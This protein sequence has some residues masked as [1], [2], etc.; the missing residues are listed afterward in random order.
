MPPDN[1]M[2]TGWCVTHVVGSVS[3][4]DL[5][6]DDCEN[7]IKT[8]TV[9]DFIV[10]SQITLKNIHRVQDPRTPPR[11]RHEMLRTATVFHS[12]F[13]ETTAFVTFLCSAHDTSQQFNHQQIIRS[14][15]FHSK[16]NSNRRTSVIW[17]DG[18]GP[19]QV[20]IH[21]L[22]CFGC[23]SPSRCYRHPSFK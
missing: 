17:L 2:S 18:P 1:Q 20:S 23:C 3:R 13:P 6:D 22:E 16:P 4:H 8:R 14:N 12:C 19:L 15:R 10:F 5:N 7:S 21:C 11:V 9:S